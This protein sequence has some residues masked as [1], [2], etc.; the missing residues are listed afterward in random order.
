MIKP[1]GTHALI[2]LL[3]SDETERARLLAEADNLPALTLN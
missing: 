2:P 3:V 1:H